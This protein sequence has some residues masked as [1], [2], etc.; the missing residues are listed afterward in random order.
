MG[1]KKKMAK[2]LESDTLFATSLYNQY[3]NNLNDLS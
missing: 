2:E 3:I 1:I